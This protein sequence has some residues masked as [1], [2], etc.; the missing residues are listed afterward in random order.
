MTQVKTY[1]DLI[2]FFNAKLL[3]KKCR[4]G[5]ENYDSPDTVACR[6]LFYE[7][8]AM[9]KIMGEEGVPGDMMEL[10]VWCK[11]FLE[12][13]VSSCIWL[14]PS[15]LSRSLSTV[16]GIEWEGEDEVPADLLV[17][18]A[19]LVRT[20]TKEKKTKPKVHITVCPTCNKRCNSVGQY[21]T[22]I[23][24]AKHRQK[25]ARLNNAAEVSSVSSSSNSSAEPSNIIYHNPY[26]FETNQTVVS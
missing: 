21:Q 2:N 13:Y 19:H 11:E 6:E 25:V 16:T 12:T 7:K 15:L 20:N 23:L 3:V 26:S 24:S 4:I 10:A 14:S 9:Y 18:P 1:N 17:I 8:M 5:E 22:H